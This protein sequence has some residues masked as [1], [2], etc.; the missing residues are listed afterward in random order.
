MNRLVLSCGLKN[1]GRQLQACRADAVPSAGQRD[2]AAALP[3]SWQLV[4]TR[5]G[6]GVAALPVAGRPDLNWLT[7][8]LWADALRPGPRTTGSAVTRSYSTER[9][10]TEPGIERTPC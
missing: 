3:R 6:D 10:T 8:A 7:P 4:A 1:L 5:A 9:G 2:G